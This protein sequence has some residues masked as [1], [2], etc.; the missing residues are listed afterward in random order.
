M[1]IPEEMAPLLLP[2]C[3]RSA[4]LSFQNTWDRCTPW[5]SASSRLQSLRRLRPDSLACGRARSSWW[6]S[7]WAHTLCDAGAR[8]LACLPR[9]CVR[10]IFPLTLLSTRTRQTHL[11]LAEM[12][13]L[14]PVPL[15]SGKS[16]AFGIKCPPP[17]AP[18]VSLADRPE[19]QNL[20]PHHHHLSV[21]P[22]LPHN[23]WSPF[24]VAA[25]LSPPLSLRGPLPSSR[26]SPSQRTG[27]P[28]TILCCA[29]HPPD[30]YLRESGEGELRAPFANL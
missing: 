21:K 13:F 27:F 8:F 14:A 12:P 17:Q 25:G 23:T 20:S 30:D 11:S 28:I 3:P 16:S 2:P 1:T 29:L 24:G 26:V 7:F 18:P 19:F 10:L 6:N 15:C 4:G 22:P 9:V 5:L